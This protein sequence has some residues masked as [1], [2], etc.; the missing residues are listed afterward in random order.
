MLSTSLWFLSFVCFI[1][2]ISTM[3]INNFWLGFAVLRLSVSFSIHFKLNS[4]LEKSAAETIELLDD[5]I[6]IIAYDMLSCTS[7]TIIIFDF[8]KTRHQIRAHV[9]RF[10][11]SEVMKTHISLKLNFLFI[12]ISET[13][14]HFMP[15]LDYFHTALVHGI[16]IYILFTTRLWF[17]WRKHSNGAFNLI[18]LRAIKPTFVLND[19][20]SDQE[21]I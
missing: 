20:I 10:T 4:G 13:E 17:L 11:M 3:I 8:F 18:H 7:W 5:F 19:D 14:M 15:Y 16:R 21:E 12:Y 1:S 6:N 2:F 9:I